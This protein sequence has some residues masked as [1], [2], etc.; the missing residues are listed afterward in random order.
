MF[1]WLFKKKTDRE[2]LDL[3]YKKLMVRYYELKDKKPEA[4]QAAY[5]EAQMVS[6]MID[7]IDMNKT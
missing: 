5:E 7:E 3:Q 4:S 2:I 6:R 1:G